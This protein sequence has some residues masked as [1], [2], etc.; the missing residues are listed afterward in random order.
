MHHVDVDGK[1]VD[2][3]VGVLFFFSSLPTLLICTARRAEQRT[4]EAA[5]ASNKARAENQVKV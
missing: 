1:S 3:Q 5:A 2:D 4:K